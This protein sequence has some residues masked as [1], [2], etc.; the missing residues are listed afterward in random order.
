MQALILLGSSDNTR[1]HP[2]HGK[3]TMDNRNPIYV[4][5][6]MNSVV[7]TYK[8]NLVLI[9]VGTN[10]CDGDNQAGAGDRLEVLVDKVFSDLSI[11]TVVVSTIAKR[12][13][14]ATCVSSVAQQYRDLVVKPKYAG[15]RIG[16]ADFHAAMSLSDLCSD[17]KHPNDGGDKTCPKVAGTARG[18]IQT[19]VGSGYDDGNYVH[20]SI[21][22]GVL[23]SGRIQKGSDPASIIPCTWLHQLKRNVFNL[24]QSVGKGGIVFGE[25]NGD[26]RSAYMYIGD[27]GNVETFINNRGWNVGIIPDWRSAGITH[28]GQGSTT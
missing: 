12:I 9:N 17:G 1:R 2:R 16:L 8:P 13:D 3:N 14:H 27:N 4:A 19:Q 20:S 23:T 21:S 10:D 18:P 28:G 25:I 24:K 22:R 11:V 26:F 7:D 15:K 6:P 5:N